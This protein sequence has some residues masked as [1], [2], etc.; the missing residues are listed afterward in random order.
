MKPRPGSV[1]QRRG[2]RC[3]VPPS[4]KPGSDSARPGPARA[5][6]HSPSIRP[7]LRR[8]AAPPRRATRHSVHRSRRSPRSVPLPG[9][10]AA[11]SY[12]AKH[13]PAPLQAGTGPGE[14]LGGDVSAAGVRRPRLPDAGLRPADLQS[15]CCGQAT[16]MCAGVCSRTEAEE[17]RKGCFP[18]Q[19]LLHA[20]VR[21]T[22]CG[23]SV[24]KQSSRGHELR[25]GKPCVDKCRCGGAVQGQ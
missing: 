18:F 14:G 11:R 9:P 10:V 19:Q 25:C 12:W 16:R 3:Q 22:S 21:Q 17:K 20:V 6:R 23:S 1:R 4:P 15:S 8:P 5:C 24:A 2:G 7:P 13:G